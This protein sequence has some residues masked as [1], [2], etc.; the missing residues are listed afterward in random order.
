[1]QKL[2]LLQTITFETIK[3]NLRDVSLRENKSKYPYKNA[4]ISLQESN[5]DELNPGALYVLEEQIMLHESLR[6]S[7]LKKYSLDIFKLSCGLVYQLDN[8]IFTM[9]PPIVEESVLDNNQPVILD[10][11]HRIALARNL[12]ESVMVIFI[13]DIARECVFPCLPVSWEQV[14]LCKAVPTIKRIPRP[15]WTDQSE[16]Y[17]SLHRDLTKINLGGSREIRAKS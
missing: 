12:K 8:Q 11:L 15:G 1:M 4:T 10:G 2:V 9:Y 7:F 16:T 3:A 5:P 13:S 6:K 17:Y 14:I